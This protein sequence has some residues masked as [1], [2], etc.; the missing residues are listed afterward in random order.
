MTDDQDII[1][2]Y[3]AL[4]VSEKVKTD[5]YIGLLLEIM[6]DARTPPKQKQKI[7]DLLGA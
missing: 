4:T 7:A 1:E 5:A 2:A 6:N 3:R